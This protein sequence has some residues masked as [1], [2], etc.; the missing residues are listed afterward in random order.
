MGGSA[1]NEDVTIV[2]S[3]CDSYEDLWYPFFDLLKKNW[4]ELPEYRI[5]LNTESKTFQMN[6]LSIE[7][8]SLFKPKEK[9]Q[10]GKRLIRTLQKISTEYV[11]FML[12]DF[13]LKSEV[14]NEEICRVLEYMKNDPMISVFYFTPTIDYEIG[15]E[16]YLGYRKL[17]ADARW[18]LNAQ[19]GLW[20]KDRFLEYIR[21]HEDAWIWERYGSERAKRY[22]EKFYGREKQAARIFDYEE[23]WGGAI[24]R[25]KWTPYAV[26]LCKDKY[27][28][29]FEVRGF[30]QNVPPFEV[31]HDETEKSKIKKV[32]ASGGYRKLVKYLKY[33][34]GIP[35]DKYIHYQSIK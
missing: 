30:E 26:E 10:W 2:V 1:M 24:H 14:D 12:D 33:L 11:L 28:I 7:C 17:K 15:E 29:N 31:T 13:F 8:F 3:S 18:K 27:D 34:K 23:D 5:V 4:K 19:A 6:G 35:R 9:V 25:G 20:R 22:P 16:P 21:P 32:L